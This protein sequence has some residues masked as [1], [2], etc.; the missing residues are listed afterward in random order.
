MHVLRSNKKGVLGHAED[1]LDYKK[2]GT[3]QGNKSDNIIMQHLEEQQRRGWRR[4]MQPL[5]FT[6]NHSRRRLDL[7]KTQ[8]SL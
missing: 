5:D 2:C 7:I 6:T 8:Q 3:V 4:D 1:S